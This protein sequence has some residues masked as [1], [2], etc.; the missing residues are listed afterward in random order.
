MSELEKFVATPRAGCT[1]SDAWRRCN[2]TLNGP[3]PHES[4]CPDGVVRTPRVVS[5][6]GSPMTVHGKFR[7]YFN[8]H[9][10]EPLMWCISPDDGLWEIAVRSVQF[11]T[12]TAETA[13]R[14]KDTPDEDDGKPSAWIAVEGQLTVFP[15]GHATIGDP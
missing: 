3:T 11:A 6:K 10:A 1:C 12:A 2:W 5:Y 15:F 8:R 14:K 4:G 7:V 13:Y 9:G